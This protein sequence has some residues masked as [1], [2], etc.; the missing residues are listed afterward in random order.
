MLSRLR[1]SG[2][3][4]FCSV[5]SSSCAGTARSS[6]SRRPPRSPSRRS[7]RPSMSP[8]P[9]GAQRGQTMELTLTGTQ[10][11]RPDA[12]WTSF[13]AKVTIPTDMNNGKDAGQA[14]GKA[15]SPGRRPDRLPLDP[16]G[17]Q[18]RHL[19]RPHVLHRRGAA[20]WTRRPTTG[21]REKAQAVPVPCVVVGKTDA[22]V[23][24]FFKVSRQAGPAA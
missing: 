15:R 20:D 19:Q 17:D 2:R 24:D 14:A 23:S 22:E 21:R 18:A 10:P 4:F 13:P 11:R 7:R 16:P 3:L 6:P 12:L 8:F 1:P 5:S 9:L